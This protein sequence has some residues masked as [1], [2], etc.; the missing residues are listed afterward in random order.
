MKYLTTALL[1][2]LALGGCSDMNDA[3]AFDTQQWSE[4]K[5]DSAFYERR[6]RMANEL[7]KQE[8]LKPGMSREDV[9][10]LLGKPDDN[11]QPGVLRYTLGSAYGADIDYLTVFFD[12]GGRVKS[13]R[14]TRS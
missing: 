12:E 13:A 7:L 6:H 10:A 2:G 9:V 8:L 1:L 11:R 14:I 3:Q 4:G 5:R